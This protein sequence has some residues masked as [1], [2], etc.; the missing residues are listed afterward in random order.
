LIII[1][2]VAIAVFFTARWLKR[3]MRIRGMKRIIKRAADQ[4]VA[5]NEYTAVIFKSYQKLGAHLRKYGYLRRDSETFREFEEAVKQA[6]PIDR[7]SMNE[8]LKLLEEARYSHHK[9]GEDQRNDAIKNLRNI[10]AS[11]ERI[12]LDESA[13]MKALEALEEAEFT[14]TEIIITEGSAGPPPGPPGPPGGGPPPGA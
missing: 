13:A 4:L 11:L 1:V 10:E 8:F 9:I 14:E 3:R 2:L 12:I 5:G 6:L 7:V